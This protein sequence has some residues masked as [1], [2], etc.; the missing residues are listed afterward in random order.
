MNY[1]KVHV[2]VEKEYARIIDKAMK[3]IKSGRV[4]TK[5]EHEFRKAVRA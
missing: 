4:K 1:M 3:E 5:N 2:R